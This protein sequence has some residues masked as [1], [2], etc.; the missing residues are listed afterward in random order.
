MDQKIHTQIVIIG[1]GPAG[2][3]AAFRCADLG[4]DVLLIERYNTLGG[5][6][7]NVG[8]I[9]S[10]SLLHIAKVI[11][12]AKELDDLGVSFNK[13][14]I[15]IRKIKNW[16]ESIIKRL[17]DGLSHMRKK[18]GIKIIEGNASFNTENSLLVKN[19]ES[20][21][22]VYFKNAIIA[23]GSHPIK[24]PSIS[25]DD[26]RIW[27]STDAL[28]LKKIPDRFLIIGSGI[29]GL[30]MATI[31]SSLGSQVDV[32]DRFKDFL[33]LV[34]K[35]IANIYVKSIN[36]RF[37]L[38]LNTHLNEI[39]VTKDQ[40]IIRMTQDDI[41]KK[42]LYYDA[43]LIAIGRM[44]N[45][46]GLGLESIGIKI[47]NFGFIEVNKQLQTNISHIYAI[48]DVTGPPMLAH[49]G[50]HEGHIAAEVISGK[51]HFFEPQVIPS[52]AYTEPEIAWVGLN[53]K[54]A[55]KQNINYEVAS[56]PWSASGR[57]MASNSSTG[58]TKLIFNKI[59][60]KIIGG[61][62]VGTNAGEL[63]GEVSLA[64]EMGCD[65]EDLA[66]TIHAHP[67]LYESIGL[68]AEVY[69]GT[70]TDLLNIK[71]KK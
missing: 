63:I 65:A 53:E 71:F 34:D 47:N 46:S 59:N 68:C 58:M 18:R 14:L 38:L 37:N 16:K 22:L 64:I 12:E 28:L 5:V 21:F 32:I 6:C 2:Y 31:Y 15:N 43:V 50:V 11:K 35:D 1:S 42:D 67:T 9:P 23:T 8:C 13:P 26:E 19:K 41:E 62:I 56:F 54:Q 49:K 3:S 7:L 48:G 24:I 51:N 57:A 61:A 60:N 44:P 39:K 30:E 29:I 45:I 10:K 52:I 27:D 25:Y 17:T 69:Q 66:L 36:K 70:V 20:Q 4:L 40:L 55:K 33:P